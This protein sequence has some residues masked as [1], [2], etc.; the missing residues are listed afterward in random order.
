MLQSE[1]SKR[2]AFNLI[3]RRKLDQVM[4]EQSLEMA[5]IID[6]QASKLGQLVGADK[7][8]TGSLMKVDNKYVLLVKMVDV[9][10]GQVDMTEGIKVNDESKLEKGIRS[11]VTRIVK[12][13]QSRWG[14]G[15]ASKNVAISEL[16]DMREENKPEYQNYII[17]V[18][19]T[20]QKMPESYRASLI[21]SVDVLSLFAKGLFLD[22]EFAFNKFGVGLLLNLSIP[23]PGSFL[24]S[25]GM[26][27][28]YYPFKV[29]RILNPYLGLGYMFTFAPYTMPVLGSAGIRIHPIPGF[30]KIFIDAGGGVM[31]DVLTP[32]LGSILGS[33]G[34]G[35][36]F[37]PYITAKVGWKF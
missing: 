10:T 19:P 28:K 23:V 33:S 7:I 24:V 20:I 14:S 18:N 16:E 22:Y 3:E 32:L 15:L 5:G 9:T 2:H 11:I 30:D 29:G 36:K 27:M 35:V 26:D 21:L 17:K 34:D 1:F 4:K 12:Q 31:V 8:I 25:F 37:L 13:G 6:N